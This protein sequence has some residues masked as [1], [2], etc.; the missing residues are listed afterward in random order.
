MHCSLCPRHS[1]NSIIFPSATD[2]E[3]DVTDPG[4]MAYQA[5]NLWLWPKPI[6]SRRSLQALQALPGRQ[7]TA[8]SKLNVHN[9]KKEQY[10]S[11]NM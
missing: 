3:T 8:S 10:M 11:V 2:R 1:I 4:Q 9:R 6:G 7:H 5:R